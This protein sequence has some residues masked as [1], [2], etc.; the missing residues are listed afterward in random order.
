MRLLNRFISLFSSKKNPATTVEVQ[1]AAAPSSVDPSLQAHC[2]SW[3]KS[4][5][6]SAEDMNTISKTTEDEFL[7]IGQNLN[8]ISEDCAGISSTAASLINQDDSGDGFNVDKVE[9]LFS[10]A[11]A[12]TGA[13]ALA[14]PDG[15][16]E[17][18]ALAASLDNISSLRTYLDSLSRSITVIGV[19]IRIETARM[20]GADF[21]SMT[22]VVDDLAQQ[23][24]VSTKAIASSANDFRLVI[25]DISAKLA[26]QLETFKKE[27]AA[28][29]AQV[30]TIINEMQDM[31]T[32]STWACK[33]IDGRASQII[34][35]VNEIVTSLQ[36][37]DICRQKMEHVA[38]TLVDAAERLEGMAE[39]TVGDRAALKKW[40]SDVVLIQIS[41]MES[42]AV[43]TASAAGGIS[44]HLT[45]I[46]D[47]SDAQA[48]DTSMILE[49]E[50]SGSL[51]V[52]RIMTELEALLSLN[53]QCKAMTTNMLDSVSLASTRINTMSEH[54]ANIVA[55]SDSISL[56]ATNALIKV[57]R[58]GEQGRALAVLADKIR[59]LSQ[60]AKNEINKGAEKIND[61]LTRSEEFRRS[62]S[63]KLYAQLA[64]AETVGERAR[65]TA[66]ELIAADK[67]M[68]QSMSTIG[69]LAKGLR[70][71][72]ERLVAG[73]RFDDIIR[74]GID[75]ITADLHTALKQ[76]EATVPDAEGGVNVQA[77]A[78][79]LNNLAKMYTMKSERDVH[80]AV[81]GGAAGTQSPVKKTISIPA[82]RKKETQDLGTNVELF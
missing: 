22:T 25:H 80:N 39:A 21:N 72:I 8:A 69:T 60:Q 6:R 71:D 70:T 43:E 26:A 49:E 32:R 61:I 53:A 63:E 57:G 56:L 11:F 16:S 40:I 27:A 48:E 54:V 77:A 20:D 30:R 18:K 74:K 81:V 5:T 36:F 65:A 15:I 13:C 44:A 82:R 31:K 47:L 1:P 37:H 23:I 7:V 50:E 9:A 55:I 67:I 34:S 14:I 2:R 28:A 73:I 58:T 59:T 45:Q 41:Q 66:P 42:V 75:S 12:S 17:M 24:E 4:F 76:L 19:L 64:D 78:A 38:K 68:I 62:I 3:Q 52:E 29:D 46:S 79:D 35:E 10:S 33:R 51:K